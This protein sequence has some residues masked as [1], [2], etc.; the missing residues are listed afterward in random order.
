[1]KAFTYLLICLLGYLLIAVPVFAGPASPNF[2][3]KD[4]GFGAG[5]S[6][7]SFSPNYSVLGTVGEVEQGRPSSTNFKAGAGLVYTLQANV[8]P[9]P[10]FSNPSHWYNKLK[11]IIATGLNPTDAQYT[12]AI[13]SDAFVSD[14]R[15]VQTDHTPGASPVW[16][17]YAAWGGVTGFNVI[18]LLP[19]V[20]Y[21]VKVAARQGNYTQVPYG[22]TASAATEYPKITFSVSG[23]PSGTTIDGMTTDVTTT[24]TDA[25]FGELPFNTAQEAASLLTTTTTASLGYTVTVAQS[26]DLQTYN[27]I[28]FPRVAGTNAV[29]SVWPASVATGAYGYHTSDH[30]LGTGNTTRFT[31]GNTFAQ[32]ET[33]PREVAYNS[34]PI[35]PDTAYVVYSIETGK[36]QPAGS[37]SH[38]LTYIATG[39]F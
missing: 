18:G 21:T 11:L 10:D 28:V 20:T 13:S 38:T 5:G 22:P 26:D 17:T 4:Y 34:G 33:T 14:T 9:A 16:Q 30:T 19:N 25:S 36:G 8:P 15:Y 1:M 7:N 31:D 39:I 2:E 37:Y 35:D 29:P 27:N 24:N 3:L 23:V 12:I 32:F 6:E